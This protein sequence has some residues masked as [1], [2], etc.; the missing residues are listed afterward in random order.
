M[1]SVDVQLY[2]GQLHNI[3]LVTVGVCG[4]ISPGELL[5]TNNTG[6]VDVSLKTVNQKT[7]RKCKNFTYQFKQHSTYITKGQVTLGTPNFINLT[8]SSLTV[9]CYIQTVS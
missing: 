1:R 3:S 9:N 7:E 2:P 5:V 4:G 6:G 8:G